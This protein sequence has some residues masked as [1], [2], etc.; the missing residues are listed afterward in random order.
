MLSASAKAGDSVMAPQADSNRSRFAVM[1]ACKQMHC[2]Q[3]PLHEQPCRPVCMQDAQS[4]GDNFWVIA[5]SQ[6]NEQYKK[7]VK[8]LQASAHKAHEREAALQAELQEKRAAMLQ[9]KVRLASNDEVGSMGNK[10]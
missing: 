7:A 4:T 8:E 2:T 5:L 10:W 9:M 3:H 1:E 6:R